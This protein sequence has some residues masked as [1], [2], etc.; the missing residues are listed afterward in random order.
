MQG[1]GTFYFEDGEMT[2]SSQ[3]MI[4]VGPYEVN[5]ENICI[6]AHFTSNDGQVSTIHLPYK[7]DDDGNLILMN[8]RGGE[9]KKK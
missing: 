2:V 3:G 8:N 6:D 1:G 4:L 7:F 9:I 5:L